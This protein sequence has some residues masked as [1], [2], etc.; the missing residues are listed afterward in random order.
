VST[1]GS[2]SGV[3]GWGLGLKFPWFQ[4]NDFETT[5]LLNDTSSHTWRSPLASAITFC[6]VTK[7]F[8]SYCICFPRTTPLGFAGASSNVSPSPLTET[9]ALGITS[10]TLQK[11]DP[12]DAFPS[13]QN[14]V[15]L[16]SEQLN[17]GSTC[18]CD[19]WGS[20]GWGPE[21]EYEAIRSKWPWPKW[22][23]SKAPRDQL[24]VPCQ[25]MDPG[26]VSMLDIN[27]QRVL[28]D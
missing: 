19:I 9:T 20:R 4:P 22:R 24:R 6:R 13:I 14:S 27:H 16:I 2:S 8:E 28:N 12:L 23:S 7:A 18:H 11:P 5:S 21:R 10:H 1:W 17:Q 15:S 26:K 25:K 3:G